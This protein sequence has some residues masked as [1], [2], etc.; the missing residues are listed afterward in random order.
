[1]RVNNKK[2]LIHS[3]IIFSF[4]FMITL[5]SSTTSA[6]SFKYKRKSINVYDTYDLKNIIND[7]GSVTSYSSSNNNIVS[8][9][10][11]GII[12]GNS[13]GQATITAR[14]SSGKNNTCL[15]SVGYYVGIDISFANSTVNWSKIKAEGIDFVMFRSSYGWYDD[16]DRARGKAYNFQYDAQLYNNIRGA[17]D[18]NIPFGIYHYSYA[19]NTSEAAL[20][21]EY[22]INALKSTGSYIAYDVENSAWQ[23]SLSKDA[24]TDIVIEYC[25]RIRNAGYTPMVYANQNWFMNHMNISRLNS[26]GYEFWFALWHYSPGTS[27]VQISNTGIY[28]LIWQHTSQG[29]I[30]GANTSSG[31]VD[32]DIMYMKERVKITFVDD[33]NEEYAT[34]IIDKGGKISSLPTIE[35]GGYYFRGWQNSSGKTI[36]TSTSFSSNDTLTPIF[37]QII[38]IEEITITSGTKYLLKNNELNLSVTYNPENTNVTK[39]IIWTSSNSDVATVNN[40]KVTGISRGTVTITATSKYDENTKA[41]FDITVYEDLK[42]DVDNNGRVSILDAYLLLKTLSEM[43]EEEKIPNSDFDNNNKTSILDAYLLLKY[44]SENI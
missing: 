12:T 26:L 36:T 1:M 9:N 11:N 7:S 41:T 27:Q 24:L 5:I 3:I 40:G 42:G 4:L 44:L 18:Y 15:I 14:D 37:E 16:Y 34:R 10:Q 8:V 32:L 23:G 20:E 2:I 38:P 19:Q 21:A 22:T 28:P 17:S 13:M 31:T 33:N 29:S 39:D 25:T 35:K 30:D 43:N 6:A